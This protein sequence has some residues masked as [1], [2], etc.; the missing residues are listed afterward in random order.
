MAYA[1]AAA[2]RVDAGLGSGCRSGED[3][4]GFQRYQVV[5]LSM[6][7]PRVVIDLEKLRH[8]NCGLG[9]YSLHL[10]REILPVAAGR[11]QPVFLLPRGAERYFPGGG[12]ESIAVSPWNKEG[13]RR[14]YRPFVQPLLTAV[15]PTPQVALWHVTSQMSK[16]LP[17]DDRVPVVLTIHDLNFLHESPADGRTEEID[18]KLADIQRK[19]NRAV[20]IVADSAYVA[21]DV[22]KHVDLGG[23]PVHVVPL[24]VSTPPV[25]SATRPAFVPAG[26]FVLT[27]GNCLPHKNFHALFGLLDQLPDMRLVIAGKKTT[28]YGEH[29][30]REVAQ[31]GLA[32]RV[33][34]P[35]EVSDGDRQWLYEHCEAFLFPSLTEGFG[36]PVLE[37]MQCGRPVFLSRRTSM[38]EIAGDLGFYFDGYEPAALAAVYREGLARYQ[39]DPAFATRLKNHAAGFSWAATARGYAEVY[40]G[41]LG[42]G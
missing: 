34:L 42:R 15:R 40:A 2:S 11:F 33:I 3:S 39:A 9:R 24:A 20:A 17:L 25:A 32:G 23:R 41:I 4:G 8:I 36:F 35:G 22:A 29:L 6:S 16:Y 19:V 14:L 1:G 28:P 10:G 27:I 30:E 31:R 12:F 5:L 13:V 26:P 18:R 37:A 38:P 7:L 21:D